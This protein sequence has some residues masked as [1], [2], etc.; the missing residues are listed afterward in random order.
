MKEDI[1]LT[2][3]KPFLETLAWKIK[4]RSGKVCQWN[5]GHVFEELKKNI[6]KKIVKLQKSIILFCF[7]GYKSNLN[8]QLSGCEMVVISNLCYQ[9]QSINETPFN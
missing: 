2:L 8:D 3:L 6:K 5:S 7:K 4:G 9:I 1:Y